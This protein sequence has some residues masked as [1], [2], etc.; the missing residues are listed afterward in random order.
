MKRLVAIF[1]IT[2][3]AFLFF[4]SCS[5]KEQEIPVASITLSQSAA[6]MIIGESITLRATISPSNVAER[7]VTWSS[8]KLFV[9][10]VDKNGKVVAN[11]EGKSTITAK[12]GD[13]E[14]T[15]VITVVA[16]PTVVTTHVASV[17]LDKASLTL[18]EEETYTLT[19]TV[20]PDDATDKSVTWS[21]NNTS[22]ATVSSTG[23]V[24]AKKVGSATITVQTNDGGKT[25]TCEVTVEASYSQT[26]SID[27][28][29]PSGT[30][31]ASCNI[32]ATS[33]EE[34]GDY[35]AWGETE[36]KSKYNWSVYKWCN[37][38]E[39]SLTKYNTLSSYGRVDNKIILETSDDVALVKLGDKWHIPTNEEWTELKTNCTWTWTSQNGVYGRK[40]TGPNGNSIFLPAAGSYADKL[41]NAKSSGYY[42][43][44]SLDSEE[45]NYAWRLFFSS[46]DIDIPHAYRVYGESIRPVYGDFVWVSSISLNVTNLFMNEGETETLVATVS[47]FYATDKSVIW[48]SSNTTV[49]TVSSSGVVTAKKAGRATIT[50]KSNIGG[51]TATCEI[52]VTSEPVTITAVDLGLSVK[53]A[54]ANI[55]AK[56]N[57]DRGNYYAWGETETKENYSW[58][59][60]RWC[61]GSSISLTKYNIDSSYGVVDNKIILEEDDDLAFVRLGGKWKIPTNDAWEELRQKCSWKLTTING[62]K[63]YKVTSKKNSASIF[64]PVTGGYQEGESIHGD[65]NS[66]YYWSSKVSTQLPWYAIAMV[67]DDDGLFLD[68]F[69]SFFAVGRYIGC[70]VRPIY[71][72]I[73]HAESVTLNKS[74]LSIMPGDSEQLTAT[75]TP[76]LSTNPSVIWSSSNEHIA[77]VNDDGV[78][79]AIALGTAIITV[80]TIDGGH[81]SSC[82]VNVVG[83]SV[84]LN[85]NTLSL[86]AGETYKL[87]ATVKPD[88][89]SDKSLIWRSYN[90]DVATVSDDGVVTGVNF[91]DTDIEVVA[92][93]NTARCTVV[94]YPGAVDLGLSVLW[95]EGNLSIPTIPWGPLG[96][97][98]H[99]LYSED[100][101]AWGETNTKYQY[102]WTNY[103]LSNGSKTTI[104]RY[105]Y[106]SSYG[107]VDN[108]ISFKDYDYK[109]DAARQILGGKWRIPTMAE[110]KELTEKCTWE[111]VKG[112]SMG[113]GLL[114]GVKITGP[115][116]NWI[117]LPACGYKYGKNTSNDRDENGYYW[118]SELQY[119]TNTGV[120]PGSKPYIANYMSFNAWLKSGRTNKQLDRSDGLSI[121]PVMER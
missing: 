112:S 32:G 106:D 21:S 59:T 12:I 66:C 30:R 45:P 80:K 108:K 4:W 5:E 109:D 110:W 34:Y 50:A 46:S 88:N 24:A 11:A 56:A 72:E 3:L 33:P 57:E 64:L 115:N 7:E 89:A 37:G 17:T 58:S 1:S 104:T 103:I 121:R 83:K 60:Y 6:E 97:S 62:V 43:S 95:A 85:I 25:T 35:Y 14:A 96:I 8:S 44:S 73:I 41:Y 48:S 42:W 107:K 105:N 52:V 118:S 53:W 13:K 67:L 81:S 49:A 84:S 99:P 51:K 18:T 79:S 31:W 90:N 102:N 100:Y 39:K 23:V 47:P 91:G 94:V 87:I 119:Y 93:D 71:G 28:G 76:V 15:C 77:T 63:G 10:S 74:S 116:G 120:F 16:A 68:E 82:L 78:V 38:T 2:I 98:I 36:T 75:I 114:D 26:V 61:N 29:L 117:Y 27:L 101:F 111:Y 9:A 54:N 113:N 69:N 86:R 70:F 40:V 55:G 22:V 19:A 65:E 20:S 92:G